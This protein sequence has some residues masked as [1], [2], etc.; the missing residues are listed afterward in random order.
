M[1]GLP[2]SPLLTKGSPEW[3]S[4]F[5]T[6]VKCPKTR[7]SKGS[8]LLPCFLAIIGAVGAG[9]SGCKSFSACSGCLFRA[10]R[11]LKLGHGN[12]SKDRHGCETREPCLLILHAFDVEPQQGF[13][14]GSM[15][16]SRKPNKGEGILYSKVMSSPSAFLQPTH[17]TISCSF[18]MNP[19]DLDSL[20]VSP[21]IKGRLHSRRGQS[22][23]RLLCCP[24][25]RT[26]EHAGQGSDAG[27][28]PPPGR[29]TAASTRAIA[30]GKL[31]A[32]KFQ[33][34]QFIC[35]AHTS[36]LCSLSKRSNLV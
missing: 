22:G 25:W 3:A 35:L 21:Q 14:T 26:D 13:L 1:P 10:S 17:L 7:C 23:L 24:K 33:S 4:S 8:P 18:L 16:P 9:R 19:R 20:L 2:I 34:A 29:R 32:S 36:G 27:D 5:S 30:S 31:K 12:G 15:A 11:G 6:P 28:P